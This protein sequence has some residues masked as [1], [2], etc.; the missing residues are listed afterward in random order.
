MLQTTFGVQQ[1]ADLGSLGR[2][3]MR[4]SP[5]GG[6]RH[7]IEAYVL[8]RQVRG[9]RS[10]AYHYAPAE[11]ALVEIRRRRFASR[12]FARMTGGQPWYGD[13][14]ALVIFSA[15]LARKAWAYRS[16]RAYRSLLLEAGHFCQTFCLAATER[17]LAPFCTG[18]FSESIIEETLGLDPETEPVVYVAGVGSRPRRVRWAPLPRGETG[19]GD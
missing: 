11:H 9:L 17:G 16:A 14:A 4:T 2:V 1:W 10:G 7:P 12:T 5:S 18:A 19:L 6:S 13:A 15:V 3:M 8:V